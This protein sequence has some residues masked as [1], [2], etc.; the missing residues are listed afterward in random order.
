MREEFE[1]LGKDF[2]T[3]GKR[4]DEMIPALRALWQGGWVSW[5]GRPRHHRGDVRTLDERGRQAERP[6]GL[7]RRDRTVR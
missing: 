1:L 6:R 3:R 7:P 5:S 2:A 4:L